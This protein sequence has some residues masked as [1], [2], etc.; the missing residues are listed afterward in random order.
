MYACMDC[1]VDRLKLCILS[2]SF[3]DCSCRNIHVQNLARISRLISYIYF[4]KLVER[5]V[6]R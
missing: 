6:K 1:D 4:K 3:Y 2:V 5:F